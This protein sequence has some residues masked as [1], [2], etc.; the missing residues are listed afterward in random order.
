MGK[1]ASVAVN[2]TKDQECWVPCSVCDRDTCHRVLGSVDTSERYEPDGIQVWENYQLIQC[3][4]CKTISFRKISLCTEDTYQDESG[5]EQLVENQELFPS[6]IAG[7]HKLQDLYVLPFDIRK[8]YEE[9][10]SA[11]CNKLAILTG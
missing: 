3:Q 1:N 5:H 6:R 2:K 7:R 8:I 4:G 11:L 9:T 10:H